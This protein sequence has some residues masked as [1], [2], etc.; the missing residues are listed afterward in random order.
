MKILCL[1]DRYFPDSN[2]NTICC[3]NIMEYFK[4]QGHQVDFFA[5]KNDETDADFSVYNG[6][7]V[8]KEGTY[9]TRAMHKY[10][11]KYNAKKWMDFPWL[12]RKFNGLIKKIQILFKRNTTQA[13]SLDVL[14]T[15][16][17]YKKITSINKHYDCLFTFSMPFALMVIGDQLMKY[18]IADKWYPVFL[19]SFVLNDCLFTHDVN[20]RKKVATRVLKRANHIFMVKGIKDWNIKHGYNPPYHE[21]TTEIFIPILQEVNLPKRESKKTAL[22]YTGGFYRDIRNPEKMFDIISS[23]PLEFNFNVFSRGCEDIVESKKEK[24]SEKIL[25]IGGY[26]SHEECLQE[27][28][29]ADFLINLGNTMKQQMPS[30]ILEYMGTGKPIINFYF[31]EEDMCLPI[32]EK[33]P[34]SI[35]INLNNYSQK[36]ID[37]L[38][39]FIKDNKGKQLSY[40]E[41]TKNLK[42]YR[43]DNI[44]KRIYKEVCHE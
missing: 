5:I 13:V 29:N 3:D 23:L 37:D 4:S 21:K 10:G 43:V 19:D 28:A 9:L 36:D 39:K 22:V 11:K 24:F 27:M 14:S 6:S 20:H 26:I 44:V 18:G 17:I 38:A 25:N 32:L 35:S 16:K 2:A 34:L 12:F 42:E 15:R 1:V 7:N 8:V 30:K 33:Y 41:A 31:V 40:E